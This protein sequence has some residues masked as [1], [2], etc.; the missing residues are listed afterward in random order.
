LS[1]VISKNEVDGSLWLKHMS[2]SEFLSDPERCHDLRFVI[3]HREQRRDLTLACF[4][5]MNMEL[6]FN[7]CHL[8]TSHRRNSDILDLRSRVEKWIPTHLS[9]ASLFWGEHLRD[10]T[11]LAFDHELLIEMK[12]FFYINLLWWIEVLSL[13]ESVSLASTALATATWWTAVFDNE[14][15]GFA[16][17]ANKFVTNFHTPISQSAPHTYLSALPFSPS[18]SRISKHFLPQFP[19][20]LNVAVGLENDWSALMNIW[21]GHRDGVCCVAFS[22][23]GKRVVSGSYD[24][25]IRVWDVE[26]G[27]MVSSPFEGHTAGIQCVAFS[28]EGKRVVSGS[29]DHSIRIWDAETGKPMTRPCEGHTGG[30]WSVAFSPN[31]KYIVSGSEDGTIRIWDAETGSILLQPFKGHT[32]GV[33]SVA[34]SP[35]GKCVA[36]GGNDN[37]LRCVLT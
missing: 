7:I 18:E 24:K 19:N 6:K 9:Y 13:I 37:V 27:Q 23:D 10:L 34:F 33:S 3:H 2:F 29:H 20:I 31:G 14:L 21:V 30:I 12:N 17:D 15:S 4:R 32:D 25:T 26:R 36:S 11:G 28:P 22:P 16:E 35:D 5:I 1:S 8:E